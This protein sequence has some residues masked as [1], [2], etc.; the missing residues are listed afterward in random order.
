M[1]R[2]LD[3]MQLYD[4]SET[5][6][7]VATNLRGYDHEFTDCSI[8]WLCRGKETTIKPKCKVELR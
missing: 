7:R 3:L 2:A 5:R 1:R 8:I 4:E 6:Q